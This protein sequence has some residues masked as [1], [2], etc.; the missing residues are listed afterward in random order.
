MDKIKIGMIGT[1]NMGSEHIRCLKECNDA[2]II[3]LADNNSHNLQAAAELSGNSPRCFS[4][5]RE[6]LK[7]DEIQAVFISTPE[8]L[9]REMAVAAFAAGKDVFLEKPMAPTMQEVDEII[10]A[11]EQS[12]KLMQ[13]GLVYRYSRFYRKMRELIVAGELAKVQMMWC[14]EFRISFPPKPWYH[15]QE[16]TGG[17]LVEKDCHHFDL[18]N[19]MIDSK[20]LRVCA[21]GGRDVLVPGGNYLCRWPGMEPTVIDYGDNVD[22]AWVIGEYVNKARIQLGLCLFLQ[23]NLCDGSTLE[24]GAIGTNGRMMVSDV[25]KGE[26]SIYGGDYPDTVHYQMKDRT[27]DRVLSHYGG[28]EQHEEFLQCIK[29][30]KQPFASGAI[31]KNSL[32]MAFAAEKSIQE[33]RIVYCEEI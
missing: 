22:H 28:M 25:G 9:H 30:R 32:L 3:A 24:I 6:L 10:A 27:A 17:A 15:S 7:M 12:G 31:G 5:Y 20:P 4:D 16:K 2:E 1:G 29:E 18:F 33:G 19:W 14:K 21:F 26:I 11:S 23:P 13:I 8:W